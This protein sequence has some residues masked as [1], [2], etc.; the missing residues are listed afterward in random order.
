MRVLNSDSARNSAG[1]ATSSRTCVAM[2]SRRPIV[3]RRAGT[4]DGREQHQRQPGHDREHDTDPH[5]AATARQQP[6]QVGGAQQQTVIEGRRLRS[7]GPGLG[8]G[9]GR[10]SRH[11]VAR[12]PANGAAPAL[13]SERAGNDGFRL[14]RRRSRS[15][16]R[17]TADDRSGLRPRRDHDGL[18]RLVLARQ[19]RR[20][21]RV[22]VHL[23]EVGD[24]RGEVFGLESCPARRAASRPWRRSAR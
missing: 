14:R 10:G 16:S 19:R 3:T 18:Q 15:A 17:G 4:V 21:R 20:A 9:A 24:E 5:Q 6:D 13:Y 22:L 7:S 8:T 12:A 23:Q 11:V 2:L 1:S